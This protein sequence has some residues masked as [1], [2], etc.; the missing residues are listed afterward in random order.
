MLSRPSRLACTLAV[1]LSTA[2]AARDV[3]DEH[4]AARGADSDDVRTSRSPPLRPGPPQPFT[5][6][7]PERI[8][9][10]LGAAQLEV[11]LRNDGKE[12]LTVATDPWLAAL[13]VTGPRGPI[14][15]SPPWP[16]I[17]PQPS[18]SIPPGASLPLRIDLSQRCYFTDPGD[19][20][21]EVSFDT[22]PEAPPARARIRL[23]LAARTWV[24]P[25]PR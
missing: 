12:P 17:S 5:L 24:N 22:V 13:E 4:G 19:Y 14:R 9:G 10:R 21:V 25:G 20:E 16:R 3:P 23:T 2:C 15:C 8:E 6:A 18:A 7:A 1:A 11:R